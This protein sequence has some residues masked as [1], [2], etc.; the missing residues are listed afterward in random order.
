MAR[1]FGMTRN[2]EKGSERLVKTVSSLAPA[3]RPTA[4]KD[5][6]SRRTPRETRQGSRAAR[7]RS[8]RPSRAPARKGGEGRTDRGASRAKGTQER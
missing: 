2:G 1:G 3:S 8:R 7:R 4:W 6:P 5:G